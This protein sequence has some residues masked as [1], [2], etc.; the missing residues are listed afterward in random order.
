LISKA[1]SF[2][3]IA[4]L[5]SLNFIGLSQD[6]RIDH[7]ITVVADLDSSVK[8]YEELGFTVKPGRL[9][10]NGLLNAHIKFSN[11]TS[12]EL[13]SIKGEPTDELALEYAELLK[14]GEGGVYLA[15]TGI[16][17]AEMESK[18]GELTIQYNTLPGKNWDYITFP[19]SSSLAHLFFIEYHIKT[20]DSKEV[21]AHNN[22]TNGIE[23]VWIDGDEKVKHLLESLGLKPVRISSDIK[24]G[25]GQGYLVGDSN[26]IVIPS[27]NLNQRPRIKA[28]SIRKENNTGNIIIRY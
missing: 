22:S 14:H 6:I 9:Q 2:I 24:L 25:A 17:T 15:L 3:L 28:I 20:N 8:A 1:I 10:A 18:L 21:L 5:S 7:L 11:N 19:E 27:N 12:L 16:K 13:M 26:I 4:F 23:T